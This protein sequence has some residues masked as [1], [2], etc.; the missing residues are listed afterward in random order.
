LPAVSPQPIDSPYDDLPEPLGDVVVLPREVDDQGRGLYDDSVITIVKEFRA[1]DVEADYLH[2]PEERSWIGERGLPP[3]VI[4]LV[5]FI[6]SKAGWSALCRLLGGKH[7]KHNVRVRVGRVRRTQ[8]EFSWDWYRI[9]GPGKEVAEALAALGT[10]GLTE[11]D[12][13][14]EEPKALPE[15][16]GPPALPE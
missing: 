9:E 16:E 7:P 5:V 8:S 14:E 2:G 13:Q 3:Q 4:N 12:D 15:G 6:A 10:T 1:L 11:R